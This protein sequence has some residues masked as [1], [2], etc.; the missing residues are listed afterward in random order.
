MEI[1]AYILGVFSIVEI[2]FKPFHINKK[3]EPLTA[4]GYV[5]NLICFPLVLLLCWHT[6]TN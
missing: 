5:I 2:L 4:L 6:I 3:K 1:I